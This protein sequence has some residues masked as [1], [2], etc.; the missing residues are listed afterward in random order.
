MR[1]SIIA[2]VV[3]ICCIT[4]CSSKEESKTAIS[5]NTKKVI[6]TIMTAP[7]D[8]LYSGVPT[9]VIGDNIEVV[10]E[11][12]TYDN[13]EKAIGDCFAEGRLEEFISKGGNMYLAEAVN[14][15]ISISVKDMELEEKG[16]LTENVKVTLEKGNKEEQVSVHVTKESDGKI[17]KIQIIE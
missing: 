3:A 12:T 11:D 14:E 5:E 17:K 9:T 10:A 8:E 6:E 7:N 1:K 15:N 16:D 2:I 4:G 13:W